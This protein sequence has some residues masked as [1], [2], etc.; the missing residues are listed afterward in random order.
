VRSTIAY[1]PRR[2]VTPKSG[3][4]A[5][6][7]REFLDVFRTAGALYQTLHDALTSPFTPGTAARRAVR[8]IMLMQILFTGVEAVSLVS[9]MGL[10]IGA[11]LMIQIRLVAPGQ[12]GEMVGKILVAVVLRELAP[13]TT[14]VIVSSRS[15]TAIAT[16]LG[17]MKANSEVLALSAMG[18]DPPRFIVLPRLFGAVVSVIVLMVYFSAVAVVGGYAVSQMISGPSF[19]ALRSGFA[20]A[21]MWQDL[22]LFLVKGTGLGVL[23]GWLCCHYGLEVKS[24]PT[25]VPQKAS[26]AVVMTLAAC[27]AYNALITGAF[28]YLVGPPVR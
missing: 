14:A 5:G 3:L 16:E 4:V 15:G 19:G 17:N 7:G 22:V 13:L 27:V 23:T 8:R 1:D 9:V 20:N 12:P 6:L 18:I 24:S 26:K 10:L 2:T 28:Y 11:T 21:L 25:E